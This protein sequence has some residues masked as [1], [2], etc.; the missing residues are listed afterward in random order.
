M[1]KSKKI[2]KKWLEKN[3]NTDNINFSLHDFGARGVSSLES[4]GISGAGHL[5]NFMGTDNIS[6]LIFARDYYNAG[7]AGY[8]VPAM[9]HST[10]TSWGRD[11]EV[12]S[13]R[14]M[15]QKNPNGIV[16][17]VADSYN[18]YNACDMFGTELKQD[19]IDNNVQLVVRPDSGIPN[20]VVS[21]CLKI[22]DQYFG[23]YINNKGFKVLN[24][25]RVLQGDGIDEDDIP[26]ILM[27][28]TMNYRFST[29]NIIF[30][31]GG[32]LLQKV[33]RDTQRC[34]FKCSAQYRDGQWHDIQKNP[35][36]VSKASKKGKLKLTK[37]GVPGTS[38]CA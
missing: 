27:S 30:G 29:E 9:E 24:N 31:M 10:V 13:Y 28:M 2:I 38:P 4:S 15:I 3:G 34:A 35:K 14:N 22:L 12:E 20:V 26:L 37:I 16:S 6:G 17:I 32:G 33:N 21:E 18:I 8:S 36:D 11:N 25:V 1:W 19:I 23:S 5:I 7:I